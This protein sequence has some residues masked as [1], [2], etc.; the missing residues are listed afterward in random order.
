MVCG[1]GSKDCSFLV[2]QS[3]VWKLAMGVSVEGIRLAA[4]ILFLHF[5]VR[6]R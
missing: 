6:P 1:D 4:G 3:F 2:P 5:S